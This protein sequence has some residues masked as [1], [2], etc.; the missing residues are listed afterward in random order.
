MPRRR[1]SGFVTNRSSP[2]SC[3]ESP[4]SRV[5]FDQ[6]SQ[7]SSAAPS[8]IDTIGIAVDEVGP[9]RDQLVRVE[10]TAL[11]A[12]G[13]VAVAPRSSPGRARSRPL[14]CPARSAASRIASIAASLEARS[15]AKPPS[16]PTAVAR[17]RSCRTAFS[18]W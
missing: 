9:E 15:G 6:A 10:R 14:A 5:S 13:A 4:S 18:A 11:E 1:R 8:S 3:T 12:V 7:S 17:P 2:T 16:S